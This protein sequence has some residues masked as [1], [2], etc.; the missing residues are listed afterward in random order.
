MSQ[1][2]RRNPKRKQ[3]SAKYALGATDLSINLPTPSS[4]YHLLLALSLKQLIYETSNI[5]QPLLHLESRSAEVE[6]MKGMTNVVYLETI[7]STKQLMRG[8]WP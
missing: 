7:H 8:F 3:N 1:I 6:S 2:L 4:D 5:V